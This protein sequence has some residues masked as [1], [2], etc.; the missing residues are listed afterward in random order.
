M[1]QRVINVL[2][3]GGKATPAPPLGPSL[4]Q[5]KVNIG[6][7]IQDLNEKTKEYAGMKVP[8]KIIIDD[9]TKEYRFEIGTPPV[10]S[11]MRKE[12]GL[13]KIAPEKKEEEKVEGSEEEGE[14]EE[15][16]M[17]EEKEEV[18]GEVVEKPKEEKPKEREIIGNLTMEQI[19]KITKMKKDSLL[20]KDG[21]KAVKEIVASVV[22][23]P[24]TIEGKTPKEILKEID[25]GKYDDSISK[26]G[27]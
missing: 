25:E 11:L 2:I 16:K 14:V 23:M 9:A 18:E 4:A 26:S 19:L 22:S 6:K 24:L 15:K 5:Y 1:A 20:A 17:V 27:L 21:K 7:I 13:S 3:D 8:V 10:S 12:L